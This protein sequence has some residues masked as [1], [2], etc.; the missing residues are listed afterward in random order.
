MYKHK[1]IGVYAHLSVPYT[2]CTAP[3]NEEIK[4]YFWIIFGS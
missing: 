3:Q 2:Q 4:K 1:H